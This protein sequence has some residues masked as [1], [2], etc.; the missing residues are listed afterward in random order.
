MKIWFV[1]RNVLGQKMVDLFDIVN[2][3][4]FML[5][6]SDD[7]LRLN[8]ESLRDNLIELSEKLT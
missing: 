5:E 6:S 4:E 7:T 3:L 8:V 2:A 1:G